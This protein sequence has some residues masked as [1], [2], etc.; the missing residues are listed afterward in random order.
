MTN[1]AGNPYPGMSGPQ[2]PETFQRGWSDTLARRMAPYGSGGIYGAAGPPALPAGVAKVAAG[3]DPT[4]ANAGPEGETEPAPV[5]TRAGA[6]AGAVGSAAPAVP[7]TAVA[8]AQKLVNADKQAEG[9]KQSKGM[10]ALA[11]QLLAASA[12]SPSPGGALAAFSPQQQAGAP[13]FK[14]MQFA[15]TDPK[16]IAAQRALE[17]AQDLT[18]PLRAL[19]LDLPKFGQGKQGT[20]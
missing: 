20:G 9:D 17:N 4:V 1:V 10:M 6:G 16:V 11:Q 2:T 12:S 15:L 14:P 8:N 13:A 19:P 5:A 7:S 3:L 18:A